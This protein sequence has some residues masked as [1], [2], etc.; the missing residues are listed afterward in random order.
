M[1]MPKVL[2]LDGGRFDAT[3]PALDWLIAQ[4]ESRECRRG[5]AVVTG[6]FAGTGALAAAWW[7]AHLGL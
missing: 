7:R 3:P 6:V 4:A 1:D 5:L 2:D